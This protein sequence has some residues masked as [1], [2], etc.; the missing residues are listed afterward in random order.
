MNKPFPKSIVRHESLT[1]TE[2]LHLFALDADEFSRSSYNGLLATVEGIIQTRLPDYHADYIP[3]NSCP[4]IEA[5]CL[6]ASLLYE[7]NGFTP[8][9]IS[10]GRDWLKFPHPPIDKL[11]AFYFRLRDRK[12]AYQHQRSA[13]RTA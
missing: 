8:D 7:D 4:T 11:L 3:T 5:F 1:P 13:N 6:C 2:L 12:R 10:K 9:E